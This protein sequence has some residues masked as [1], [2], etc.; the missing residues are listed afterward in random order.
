LIVYWNDKLNPHRLDDILD[1]KINR[2]DNEKYNSKANDCP[3]IKSLQ[4]NTFNINSP[5]GI[6][7]NLKGDVGQ[8]YLQ[9]DEKSST[10][11]T[12][13]FDDLYQLEPPVNVK[14]DNRTAQI[15]FN[16][17]FWTDSDC[18]IYVN[19]FLGSDNNIKIIP[20]YMNIARWFRPLHFGFAFNKRK[21]INI[22]FQSPLMQIQ[23]LPFDLSPVKLIYKPEDFKQTRSFYMSHYKNAPNMLR[24]KTWK[25]IQSA[26]KYWKKLTSHR[27]GD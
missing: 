5:Y 4:V 12:S 11:N 8:E 3:S 2:S 20:G 16:L 22:E 23:F 17:L 9:L 18:I 7:A 1:I 19:K 27:M 25:Y 6:R 21:S 13:I 10:L 24:G 26:E 15:F 14:D